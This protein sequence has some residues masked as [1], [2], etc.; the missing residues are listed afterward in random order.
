MVSL[1]GSSAATAASR[2]F[3]CSLAWRHFQGDL[4]CTS[5]Q[6]ACNWNARVVRISACALDIDLPD[7]FVSPGRHYQHC[8]AA[9]YAVGTDLSTVQLDQLMRGAVEGAI[10]WSVCSGHH[11]HRFGRNSLPLFSADAIPS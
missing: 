3:R 1:A 7:L 4:C 9:R 11:L 10:G 8:N 2:C 6:I 5:M